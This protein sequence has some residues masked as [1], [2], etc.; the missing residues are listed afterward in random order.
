QQVLPVTLQII[1]QVSGGSVS[2][3]FNVTV[4]GP[5]GYSNTTTVTPGAPTVITNLDLGTYTVVEESPITTAAPAGMAW[6]AP[7]Y[8]P[9]GGSVSISSGMTGTITVTNYLGEEPIAPTGILTV[10]KAVDWNG[11]TPDAGQQFAYTIDGPDGFTPIND[12]ITDGG[13][14]TYAAPLGVYTVTETSPGAGWTTVYTATT[15]Y[16]T[17]SSAVVTM[18]NLS[19]V[20]LTAPGAISGNVFRDFDADG[21]DDGANEIGVANVVVTAYDR[22]NVAQGMATTDANGNYTLNTTGNGPYRLAFTNLPTGYEPTMHGAGS[23]TSTQFVSAPASNVNFGV[24][25]PMD[26]SQSNPDVVS[27]VYVNGDANPTSRA[28]VKFAYNDSGTSPTPTTLA[29]KA[30][31]GSTWGLAYARTT[32]TIYAAAFL[33]R[34][35]G[36]GPNGLGAIYAVDA[37]GGTPTLF[38]DL[39]S[40]GADIGTIE[41]NS[42]RGLGASSEPS[43]DASTFAQIGKVGLG[44]LDISA[45]ESMLYV[46]SMNDKT[47]YSLNIPAGTLASS[48]VIPDPGCVGGAWRPFGLKYYRDSLYVGGV[49]D[50][51]S[52][53]LKSDLQAYVYRFTPGGNTFTQVLVF[54]LDYPRPNGPNA[55]CNYPWNPWLDTLS[56]VCTTAARM[57]YPQAML[58]DIE[59]DIDGTM[60]LG[61]N[62]RTGHQFGYDNYGPTS[63]N[64]LYHGRGLGD[65]LRA[66]NNNGTFVLENNATSGSLTTAGANNNQGPGGGEFYYDDDGADQSQEAAVGG[67]ALLPGRGEVGTTFRDPVSTVEGGVAWLSNTTGRKTRTYELYPGSPAYFGKSAGVGDLELLSDPAPIEIGNRVWDDLNGNGTQDPGEPGLNG[68]TVTLQTPTGSSTTTTSGDGNYYFA[69]EP[70]TTYTMTVATPVGYQLTAANT[71]ALDAANLTSNH[72]ISDTIDSDALLVSGTPTIL[73]TTGGPGQNNHSLDFG[74]VQPVDGQVDMLNVVPA[75]ADNPALAVAKQLNGANP[76]GVGDTINF[77]IRITNTGN[78]AITSLPLED[79]FSNAFITF[80]SA[81]PAPDGVNGG[82]LTWSNLLAG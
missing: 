41:S 74:F 11:N 34:H 57:M 73:Y 76:F 32:N 30:Q 61:L 82:I 10:T 27:N 13:V 7:S 77:T 67:L 14:M 19:A 54:P 31:V 22:N 26:Y 33:K 59:F 17:G 79:R 24:N 63:S 46:V 51:Q 4:T 29:T 21:V 49:C 65:I 53:Q 55:G 1:K 81:N 16:S 36:M 8:E 71:T 3:P 56:T 75:V 45:D 52:S 43:R 25:H 50:A 42:A 35:V 80:V 44:D 40:L 23:G 69:V 60:I 28:V 58:S 38:A 37:N 39:A 12:T 68:L 78:V 20:P 47:L 2:A 5:N 64:T 72:A 18:T 48:N 66:T 9:A 6:F 62:D 70:Y 15:G